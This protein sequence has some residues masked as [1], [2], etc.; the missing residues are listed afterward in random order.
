MD[1]NTLQI[2]TQSM[3]SDEPIKDLV[4]Q[5]LNLMI[6]AEF[7]NFIG[8]KR[9]ERTQTR[10]GYRNGTRIKRFDTTCGTILLRVPH[11]HKG[12]YRPSFL[13]DYQR[14]EPA[15]KQTIATA[16]V[17]GV[18]T[19]RMKTLVRSM[20]VKGISKG[21]VTHITNELNGTVD[22]FRRRSL[23]DCGCPVLFID[24]VF[25]RVRTGDRAQLMAV[26]TVIG[27]NA[28]NRR[29]VLA[30]EVMPDESAESYKRLLKTLL[31]R[32]L[33][34]PRL[35]VSDGAAGLLKAM[36]EVLPETQW[37]RCC[38]HF[39][40]NVMQTV[41]NVDKPVIAEEIKRVWH[42]SD[43]CLAYMRAMGIV[44]KYGEQYP[45]AMDCLRMGIVSTLTYTDF[46]EF[47]PKC[48][49]SSNVIERLH[50]EF[51]R[52]SKT[53]GAFPNVQS[54]IKL[55]TLIAIERNRKWSAC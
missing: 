13:R 15:L 37:Q 26:L 28:Q 24:A 5:T 42:T 18:S 21:Q 44:E 11:L 16:Y 6:E 22:A 25:E 19:G 33:E 49:K 8:A 20:G 39:M 7:E 35:I 47:S 40:R 30:V 29:Q 32:G 51:R 3:Q 17:N 41:R 14:Y 50:S 36:S 52:R 38:V 54:C 4:T 10:K 1:A 2:L 31:N 48:I 46:K 23:K 53:I 55:F 34:R 27:M 45:T 12:S 9:S 43:K